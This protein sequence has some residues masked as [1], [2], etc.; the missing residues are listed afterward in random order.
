MQGESLQIKD[1]F[2]VGPLENIYEPEGYQQ[3][4]DWWKIIA[5]IFAVH[6]QM[7]IVDD[8]LT[9]HNLLKKLDEEPEEKV[10]IW[11]G[12]NVHDVSGITG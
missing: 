5:R 2:A 10:W 8:K 12:Q 11:M 3:R 1:E 7:D 6:R 4:S 9:V